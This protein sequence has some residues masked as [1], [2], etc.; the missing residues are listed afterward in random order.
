[1]RKRRLNLAALA[2]NS[3]LGFALGTVV[4]LYVYQLGLVAAGLLFDREPLWYPDQVEFTVSGSEVARFGGILLVLLVGWALAS[5]YRGGTGYDGT[6]LTVLWVTLHCF[7]Q[8]LLPLVR[9]FFDGASDA[10]R[11]LAAL[12]PP[13]LLT[14]VVTAFGIAGLLGLG[15]LAAPALLRFAPHAEDLSTKRA[16]LTFIGV[17]GIVAWLVGA[18]L[19]LPLLLPDAESGALGLL[20]WSGVFLLFTLVASPEPRDI[21]PVRRPVRLAWGTLVLLGVLMAAA[22]VF[23]VD[24]ISL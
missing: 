5:I 4:A 18:L 23:L 21:D 17:V 2:V 20:P 12:D 7:R 1:M 14:W 10:D 8:G 13:E 19:V 24:G 3:S 16:R 9:V 22:K 6:R 11:A 15:L